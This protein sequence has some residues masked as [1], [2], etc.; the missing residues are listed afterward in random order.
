MNR[1]Q[2][3][4]N[5]KTPTDASKPVATQ[6][7]LWW[8]QGFAHHQRGE[9]LQAQTCYRQISPSSP[10]YYQVLGNLGVIALQQKQFSD[11]LMLL[12]Q[13]LMIQPDFVDGIINKGIVL[14]ELGRLDEA[15]L[16]YRRVLSI[17]PDN[18]LALGN[19][20]VVLKNLGQLEEAEQ[21]LQKVLTLQPNHVESWNNLGNIQ[22]DLGHWKLAEKSYLK[23]LAIRPNHVE[24]L[25]NLGIIY[26]NL[27]RLDEAQKV[28]LHALTIR[29]NYIEV[30]YNLG[31]T[32]KELGC[33]EEAELCY[34]KVL[35]NQPNYAEAYNNL[36]N[37]QQEQNKLIE[38]QASYRRALALKPNYALAHKHLGD[39]LRKLGQEDESILCYRNAL[40][41]D[42]QDQLGARF[43]LAALGYEPLPARASQ[44]QLEMIYTKR[45]HYWD[46]LSSTSYRGAELVAQTMRL[47]LAPSSLDILDAGCGTG[48]VGV[49]IRDLAKRLDGIDLSAEMLEKAKEKK[50]YDGLYQGDLESFMFNHP[51]QYDAIG[52]AATF[53]HFGD[54]SSVFQA[55][56]HTLRPGGLLVFTL[57]SNETDLEGDGV[58]I[59]PLEGFERGGCYAHGKGHVIQMA[60]K[61]GFK[62]HSLNREIH[63]TIKKNPVQCLVVTLRL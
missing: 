5:R 14:K 56:A 25:F 39:L 54:L 45:A 43:S 58:V 7:Q 8:N 42:P 33:L 28:F 52:S 59:N 29:P 48:M 17:S 62:V 18:I 37:V 36:G 35:S 50:I 11:S 22:K 3:R 27:S 4:A 21:C 12:Q 24:I 1:Q 30:I 55:A 40:E 32:Y 10:I 49:L 41:A 53:I 26:K 9:L 47:H 6:D 20:G 63:E 51:R 34:L 60:K 2:R 15:N 13:A 31:I 57:F 44:E 23:A 46:Q 38:A 19:L 16:C 61:A